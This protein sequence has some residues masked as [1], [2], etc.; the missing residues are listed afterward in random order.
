MLNVEQLL[1]LACPRCS[2]ALR[3]TAVDRLGCE[4]GHAFPIVAGIPRFVEATNY[5]DSFGFQWNEFSR[6]QLDSYNGTKFSEDRFRQITGWTESDLCGKLVLDAGCGAGRFAEVALK[7]FK[8]NLIACDLSNAV[9][10]CQQNVLPNQPLICQASIYDLPFRP[11]L[12][13]FVYCIGVIQHT[14]DPMGAIRSLCRLV[15]P[16]GQIGLWIYE[17][18]WKTFIGTTGF[19]YA[20]RPVVSRLS[21][22]RQM[23]FCNALVELFWPVAWTV[24]NWGM[25]GKA[26]MRLL[27]TA[28]AH[29]QPVRLNAQDFKRWMLLD[30]FD[31]YTPAYDQPQ[32]FGRVAR[33]LTA[34]GFGNVQRHPHGAISVTATRSP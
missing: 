33:E 5:A 28:S 1:L 29:L 19:K 22:E 26:I 10:A 14:P 6:L 34:R 23:N 2:A 30:T 7:Q 12:F 27:P 25:L 8:A 24:K 16:G 4:S 13:D 17:V 32:T 31:A 21:R 20:L 15:K 9:E 3:L 18:D 11:G